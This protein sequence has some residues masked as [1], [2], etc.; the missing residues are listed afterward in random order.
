MIPKDLSS[1]KSN[2]VYNPK[3]MEVMKLHIKGMSLGP[4]GANSYIL[5]KENDVLVVDPGGDAET[6]IETIEQDGVT[7]LA[8]LLTHAHFDHIGA[9][10]TIRK[11]YNIDVYL[12]EQEKDWLEESKLNRSK[13]FTGEDIVT[14]PQEHVLSEGTFNIGPFLFEVYHTP[15]HSPGSVSYVFH[16]E[17]K[18]VSGDVLFYQGVG[19]TDLPGGDVGDLSDSIK[20]KLYTLDDTFTVFPGHGPKTTIGSEKRNNPFIYVR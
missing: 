2:T 14:S 12:H 11:H 20:Q 10:D 17:E 3:T 15:G 6:I 5:Q 1:Y 7:P 9:L 13:L 8:I 19:R 16:E 4:L 18:V